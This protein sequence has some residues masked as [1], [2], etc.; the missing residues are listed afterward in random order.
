MACIG[1]R[2]ASR[3]ILYKDSAPVGAAEASTPSTPA[4]V[5]DDS[6]LSVEAV[7]REIEAAASESEVLPTEEGA[8]PG[9]DILDEDDDA[10]ADHRD[11]PA[12]S[13][14][15]PSVVVLEGKKGD[16]GEIDS[17]CGKVRNIF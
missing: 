6:Q 16:Q 4:A 17:E 5:D 14:A 8:P 15:V 10:A 1:L 12:A 3:Q 2:F 9:I 7:E 13:A 11:D